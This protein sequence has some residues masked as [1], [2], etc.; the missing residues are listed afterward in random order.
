M[1]VMEFWQTSMRLLL[2]SLPWNI[3]RGQPRGPKK[4][5]IREE[6]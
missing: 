5:L 3:E 2:P 1:G 6:E 4:K